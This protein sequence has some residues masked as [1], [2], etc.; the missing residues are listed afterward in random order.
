MRNEIE[1]KKRFILFVEYLNRNEKYKKCWQWWTDNFDKKN[2]F[3]LDSLRKKPYHYANFLTHLSM[4]GNPSSNIELQYQRYKNFIL[5]PAVKFNLKQEIND[6]NKLIKCWSNE[7]TPYKLPSGKLTV[8]KFIKAIESRLCEKDDYYIRVYINSDFSIDEITAAVSKIITEERKK[9][10]IQARQRKSGLDDVQRY[11]KV[12][13]A[14]ETIID[15][16]K[17]KWENVNALIYPKD[18]FEKKRLSLLSDNRLAKR[19]INNSIKCYGPRNF[20]LL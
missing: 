7:E 4:L 1:S 20:P 6:L 9:R 16:K 13:D 14:R 19:I 2:V 3:L 18:S 8:D 17:N 10:N 11:L 5:T 12:Y 15:G